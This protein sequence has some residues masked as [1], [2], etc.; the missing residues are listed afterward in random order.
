MDMLRVKSR[1]ELVKNEISQ[2]V[3]PYID[4]ELR[5]INTKEFFTVYPYYKNKITYYFGGFAEFYDYIDARPE[6][7]YVKKIKEANSRRNVRSIRDSLAMER[8]QQL[9]QEGETL[10]SIGNRYG[11]TKQ[12]VNQLINM[13]DN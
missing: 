10:E 5:T 9:R 1:K 7:N 8:L 11:V 13:L 12:A 4:E 6:F 2:L 3:K